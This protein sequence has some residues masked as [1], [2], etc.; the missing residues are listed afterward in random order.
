MKKSFLQL[1]ALFLLLSSS[2]MY[3]N[4]TGS[5]NVVLQFGGESRT[6]SCYVPTNYDPATKYDLLI[7]LHGAG[8]NSTN[9]RNALINQAQW[10]NVFPNTIMIFPD[11]GSDQSRDFFTP[12]GDEEF[13]YKAIELIKENYNI[14]EDDYI[15]QG[16]SLGGRSALRMGL[17]DPDIFRGLLL[18]TPAVQ[19]AVDLNDTDV[20][21]YSN[22]HKLNI[23]IFW[24]ENDI[25]YTIAC[26]SLYHRLIRNNA[27]VFGTGVE[28]MG[29]SITSNAMT[30][31]AL[32]F[33][34]QP[35]FP[36]NTLQLI[37]AYVP[38]V[39]CEQTIKP[40]LSFR[41]LT[42]QTITSIDF[43]IYYIDAQM[44]GT[45]LGSK[46]YTMTVEP[47]AYKTITFDDITIPEFGDYSLVFTPIAINGIELTEEDD[48][49]FLFND[50]MLFNKG[51]T[52][53]YHFDFEDYLE[54]EYWEHIPSGN[55]LSWMNEQISSGPGSYSLFL[56]NT[57]LLF[58][59]MGYG[60]E[61]L[62][63]PMNL[64]TAQNP[65]MVLDVA[66]TYHNWGP[67]YFNQSFSLSDTLEIL[68]STDCGNTFSRVFK[69]AGDELRTTTSYLTNPV[70]IDQ[71][72]FEPQKRD[73]KQISIDLAQ[74]EDIE[75][76]RFKIRYIS[77]LGGCIFIDDFKVG[78]KAF[79]GAE[80]Y[81]SNSIISIYPN[82][83]S[84]ILNIS[85]VGNAIEELNIYDLSGRKIYSKSY[86]IGVNDLSINVSEFK[87]GAYIL[88]TR[89]GNKIQ[90]QKF[91]VK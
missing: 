56:F 39:S 18:H 60:E 24:G 58:N 54:N 7:G 38:F 62:S 25:A 36:D 33:I 82:P 87:S 43:A 23:V 10:N 59:N 71:G 52:L 30:Q 57:I 22:A 16:F 70:S 15:I 89:T 67:P 14:N 77:G 35:Y 41:S 74:Y 91:I 19:G 44:N 13:I 4:Q 69:K 55:N 45:L 51:I 26:D 88:E 27:K 85:A 79:V 37:K 5:F 40:K 1:F 12:E 49:H 86:I 3:A 32:G 78:N 84:E 81:T 21:N 47:F 48:P 50:Y 31:A 9:Y 61:I 64:T 73:W 80:D 83:V 6:V 11:G 72:I 2:A 76:A 65:T 28:N 63:P 68:I 75:N 34:N 29:H 42:N 53:P 8:D 46:E 17:N 66:F 20:Y 90:T